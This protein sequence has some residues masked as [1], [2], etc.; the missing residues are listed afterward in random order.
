MSE[1]GA[2]RFSPKGFQKLAG[3][4]AKRK[5]PENFF[6]ADRKTG[7]EF[8]IIQCLFCFVNAVGHIVNLS[9]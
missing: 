3:G 7:D 4:R 8:Q 6:F 1:S 9:A 5:P 2:L